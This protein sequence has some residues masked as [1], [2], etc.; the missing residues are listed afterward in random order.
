MLFKADF[1]DCLIQIENCTEFVSLLPWDVQ[2][3]FSRWCCAGTERSLLRSSLCQSAVA[4]ACFSPSLGEGGGF[5]HTYGISLWE[6]G[7]PSLAARAAR[8]FWQK[9]YYLMQATCVGGQS[10]EQS[11]NDRLKGLSVQPESV[12]NW[13]PVCINHKREKEAKEEHWF[14]EQRQFS[15]NGITHWKTLRT[16]TRRKKT[17]EPIVPETKTNLFILMCL[18]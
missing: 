2:W 5:F 18:F 11:K 8:P 16:S 17:V 14:L 12:L 10:V 13:S 3:H 7:C 4:S 9:N 6:W 15:G 1:G